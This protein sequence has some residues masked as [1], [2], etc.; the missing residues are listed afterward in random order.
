VLV[1]GEPGL[2]S[3]EM[4]DLEWSDVDFHKTES[5]P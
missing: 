5:L 3:G 4:I 1:G 2:R